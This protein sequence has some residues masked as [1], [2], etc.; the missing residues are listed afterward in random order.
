MAQENQVAQKLNGINQLLDW[1]DDVNQVG[2][3]IDTM[4]KA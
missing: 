4:K 3:N 2:D 1:A